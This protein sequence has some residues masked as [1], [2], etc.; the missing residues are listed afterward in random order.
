MLTAP[1]IPEGELGGRTQNRPARTKAV[2]GPSAP[3]APIFVKRK[4]VKRKTTQIQAPG[5]HP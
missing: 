5:C 4:T 2:C 1:S 3:M